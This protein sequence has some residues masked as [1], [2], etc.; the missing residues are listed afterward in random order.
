MHLTFWSFFFFSDLYPIIYLDRDLETNKVEKNNIVVPRF[1]SRY[2]EQSV[3]YRGET[4][5]THAEP[6]TIDSRLSMIHELRD[7]HFEVTSASTADFNNDDF[8]YF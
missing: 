6:W 5:I 3:N 4:N 1:Q 2:L 8:I 7:L